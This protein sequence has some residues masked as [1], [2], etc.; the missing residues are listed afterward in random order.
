MVTTLPYGSWPSPIT[1]EQLAVGGNRLG[2]P[3]WVGDQLW[4]T[5]GLAAEGGRQAIVRTAGAVTAETEMPATVTVLPAPFNAR[6]RVNEYGGASWTALTENDDAAPLVLFVN[7]ADQRIYR[8]R[9]GEEPAPISPVGMEVPA[10][11]GSSLRWAQPTPVTLADGSREVWWVCEQHHDARDSSGAPLIERY[12]V[13]VPLDGSAAE[14]AAAIR[15]VTPSARFVAHPRLSAD[16]ARLA[17][18]SWEHPQMP[19]DGTELHVG[20]LQDGVVVNSTV[21]DGDTGTSVLNPEWADADTLVYVSDRSGWWNPWRVSFDGAGGG[22]SEPAQLLQDEQEYAGP[23][24]QLGMSWLEM[25]GPDRAL[26]IHGTATDSLGVVNLAEGSVVELGLA[27]TAIGSVAY[28]ADG[29]VAVYGVQADEFAA[30]SVGQLSTDDDGARLGQLRTIRSSRQDAPDPALLPVPEPITVTTDSGQEVHAVLYRPRQEGFAAPEAELP[31]FIAQVHGGPTA[32]AA[33]GLSLAIAYYTS[34]G[35]GVVDIN[36]GGSTGFGRAYRDRL[37]GQWGVVDVEDTVAVMRHLV[38]E[39]IADGARLGIE[40]GS[41]GGWTTLAC[42]TRTDVFSAGVSS[43]G[44]ADA[45]ALA[46]DTHDFESRYLDQLIGRYP[47]DEQ[48]YRER[49]PLNHVD[50]LECPVLLLQGDEDRIVPPNQAE[51]FRDAMAAK[52]IP[53][54]YL[55]FV[56]EQHGFRKAENIVASFEASLSFYGQIFGFEP[57][58]VAQLQL[59]RG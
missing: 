19:W 14:D 57:P 32:K 36:Y 27:A 41:A 47:E 12:I 45:V 16:G 22:A 7:F 10:A 38:R 23:L 59:T 49:A 24:W 6:S 13:A 52:G 50:S 58:G 8:F 53:H 28:R 48:I 3:T 42:L 51:K 25:I 56:G 20:Q 29:L 17:W 40:G 1:A 46:Q 26:S 5:E 4:W 35:I 18:I 39:G 2:G 34:R 21:L 55:L 15:R 43:F 37:K 30:I 33:V 9:E 31:P 44:V 54:A 11:H